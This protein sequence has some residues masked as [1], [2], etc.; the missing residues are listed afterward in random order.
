M[1]AEFLEVIPNSE[2]RERL[3]ETVARFRREGAK[4]APVVFGTHRK[5]EGVMLSFPLFEK[6]LPALEEVQ[7]ALQVQER[8]ATSSASG[9]FEELV[10]E[11]G[12]DRSDFE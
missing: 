2:A 5:P 10:D 6:L 9:T 12:F 1:P 4:A 8:V 7:L 11:L 3:G